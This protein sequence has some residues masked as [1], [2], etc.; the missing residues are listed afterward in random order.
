MSSDAFQLVDLEKRRLAAL[1]SADADTLE[2]LHAPEFVLVHPGGGVWSRRHYLDGVLSGAI[3]YRR[4]EAVST[5]E[6]LR[7]GG[8]AVLRYRS[9]MD[10]HVRGQEPGPLE[11]RHMDCYRAAPDGSRWWAVW[12]QA[13]EIRH[14]Q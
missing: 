1:V 11:C 13:T 10:I 5:I 4:F 2:A 12:S 9:A 6:V 3:D 14:T 8:L 7:D